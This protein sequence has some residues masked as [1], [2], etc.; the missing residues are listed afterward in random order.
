MK[1]LLTFLTTAFFLLGLTLPASAAGFAASEGENL[2]RWLFVLAAVTVAMLMVCIV[3]AACRPFAR[4]KK[5]GV[6]PVVAVFV[7]LATFVQVA[8]L[9]FCGLVYLNTV[10][11]P[12]TPDNVQVMATE[13]T[14]EPAVDVTEATELTEAPTT[15]P[16]E[17][18]PPVTEPPFEPVRTDSSDPANWEVTWEVLS[19][20]EV[21]EDYTRE[22]EIT[23][24]DGSEY[25]ALP[26]IPTFRGNNYRNSATYGTA[27]ITTGKITKAWSHKLGLFNG[28]SGCAWTG[29]PL[30]VQWDEET[31]AIMNL[32]D[33]KK[34]KED[35]VE[36]IWAKLDGYVHFYDL[37]DG[38]K[39]RDP[40]Y[41]G[42]NFKGA[43]ALDPRGY[44]IFYVGGG[45]RVGK[46]VQRMYA[47][48]L[49]DGK[50]L[51]QH[52][53]SDKD[54]LREW[55]AFDSSPLVDA[56]T[57]TLI[58]PG[59]DG[60]IYTVKLN[61]VYDKE[62]G[63]L[64][65]EP[66]EPVKT[67][68]TSMYSDEKTYDRYLGYEASAA[69]VENY[70]YISENGG[71]FQCIDL[72]TMNLVWAQD[73]LDDS[74]STPL[75]DWE[76]DGNGYIYTAPSLHWTQE[77]H[78]GTISIYKLN[79][80]TGEIV[81]THEMEC[82]TYDDISGGVQSSPL[83][84]KE[85]SDIEGM[86]FYMVGRSPGAWRGQLVALD[87]YT[88]EVIWQFQTGN[89]G[90]SSPVALYTEEGKA[91]IFQADASGV[92]YLLD[93]TTGEKVFTYDIDQTVE[94]SPVVFG[95]RLL[96]GSREAV[97]CFKIS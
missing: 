53:N 50:I 28:W 60:L 30:V 64:T 72:N 11:G 43:G 62:A 48:S 12:E 26:G 34:E 91:Y 81:W 23:F 49:I 65:M 47:I 2:V 74:N 82:V 31:K 85:G 1:K 86:I 27:E 94:A 18:E 78:E 59:E 16:E 6:H 33:E 5:R 20:G 51:W 93:G 41:V 44:P 42:V 52:G 36:V 67:R 7:Y 96:I 14:T 8:T 19:N 21:L 24:A 71:L 80:S 69:I 40:I 56:E 97:Y 95:N 45:I 4:R 55:Y 3:I 10:R 39:T 38:S 58:W 37:D 9:I 75:F 89:Y 66:S 70:L 54:A 87:K 83:L 79:A 46:T 57:D 84:G 77:K 90:W 32:Y 29:Q 76:E 35:L 92:C 25:F 15:E 68:Y 61:T 73:T 88:G 17:T 13:P 63:T 22:E